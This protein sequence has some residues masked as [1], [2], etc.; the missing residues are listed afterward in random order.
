MAVSIDN[1]YQRVLALANKEQRGYVTPQE[2]NLL[3][4]KA[5]MDIF[6]NTLNEYKSF[7]RS[8]TIEA[9]IDF[10]MDTLKEKILPFKEVR[11]ACVVNSTDSVSSGVGSHLLSGASLTALTSTITLPTNVHYLEYIQNAYLS[12]CEE[13]SNDEFY[14][15]FGNSK[16]RPFSLMHPIM[17]RI[18]TT[19]ILMAPGVGSIH[20]GLTLGSDVMA[21]YIKKPTNPKWGY[22]IVAEK[23]LYNANTSTNFELHASEESTLTNRILELAGIVIN[24][25]GLSEVAIRNEQLKEV[26]KNK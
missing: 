25:P 22:V 20:S 7:S 21:S 8:P 11:A 6:E 2:F 18:S 4:Y 12:V 5:Q 16:L 14:T 10:S 9:E 13:V 23:A 19:Q 26:V 3:A 17:A 1:V 24:K 15:V